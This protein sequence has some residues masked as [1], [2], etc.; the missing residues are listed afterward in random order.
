M[1]KKCRLQSIYAMCIENKRL[2]SYF[3]K[4]F[5]LEIRNGGFMALIEWNNQYS[6]GLNLLDDQHKKL[7]QLLNTLHDAMKN[8]KGRDLLGKTLDEL[9]SYTV[10]HFR[11][12]EELFDKHKYVGAIKHKAEHAELTKQAVD[13][14]KRFDG[15]AV[16]T[17]EVMNFLR[18]WLNTHIMGSD[19]KYSSALGGVS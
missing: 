13:L 15:G 8:G 14:K 11:T 9:I 7:F 17:L 6:V 4:R 12:E 19:K 1:K 2:T 16:L 18:D 3:I 5:N 10:T